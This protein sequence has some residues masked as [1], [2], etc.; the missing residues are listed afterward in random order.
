MTVVIS[1]AIAGRGK[2]MLMPG[3]DPAR[4][5]DPDVFWPMMDRWL[6]PE[7]ARLER[8]A[9]YTFHS[10]V[11][12]GWR[13]GR[14]LL[15]GDPVTRRRLSSARAL[16]AG[17]ARCGQNL[18]WKLTVIVKDGASDTLLDIMKASGCRMWPHFHR[19]RRAPR[20]GAAGDR[21]RGRRSPRPPLRGWR[22]NVRLPAAA[23]G[24]ACRSTRRRC[25]HHLSPTA[26][27]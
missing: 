23:V 16:C 4:L 20:R 3:D 24:S 6:G 26:A 27:G 25:R 17:D 18:A 7:D 8:A 1:A 19:S 15:A 22:G 9:V 5:T 14:L 10:V 2:I 13:K 21:S 12:E 11:Q